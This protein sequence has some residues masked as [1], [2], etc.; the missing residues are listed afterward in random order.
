M[1]AFKWVKFCIGGQYVLLD[2]WNE[3]EKDKWAFE[4]ADVSSDFY[5]FNKLI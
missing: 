2:E 1:A 3:L 5:S 4:P